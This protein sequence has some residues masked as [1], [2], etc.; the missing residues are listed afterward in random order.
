MNIT[1]SSSSYRN[2]ENFHRNLILFP[3]F[4]NLQSGKCQDMSRL[5]AYTNYASTP[6]YEITYILSS[7]MSRNIL[8][9][10]KNIKNHLYFFN[11]KLQQSKPVIQFHDWHRWV[12][13]HMVSLGERAVRNADRKLNTQLGCADQNKLQQSDMVWLPSGEPR[14]HSETRRSFSRG[15]DRPAAEWLQMPRRS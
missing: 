8:C 9:L 13:N 1:E 12:W 5:Q 7:T 6:S 3:C 15:Y 2:R 10:E 11:K 4:L 14:Q